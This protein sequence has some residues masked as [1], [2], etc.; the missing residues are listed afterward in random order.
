MSWKT[1]PVQLSLGN[2]LTQRRK[3]DWSRCLPSWKM[4]Q[5]TQLSQN[6]VLRWKEPRQGPEACIA[7]RGGR[8]AIALPGD[9]T[10]NISSSRSLRERDCGYTEA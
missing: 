5:G 6:Y 4:R 2:P 9:G 7:I 8:R 1:L 3:A 10:L